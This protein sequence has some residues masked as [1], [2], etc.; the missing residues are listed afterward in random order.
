MSGAI[1]LC[2]TFALVFLRSVQQLNVVHHKTGM[3]AITS[4]LIAGAEVTSI[5]SVVA[6]GWQS[7]PFVGAG[8][9]LGVVT[10]MAAHKK[11]REILK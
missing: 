6:I 2:A 7:V 5:L 4:F 8:G 3:A 9:A 11:L 10:A 1:I